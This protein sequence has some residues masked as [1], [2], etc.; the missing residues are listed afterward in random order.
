M[1]LLEFTKPPLFRWLFVSGF[2]I[3]T[4]LFIVNASIEFGFFGLSY[5]ELQKRN[6]SFSQT[7]KEKRKAATL[8]RGFE[9]DPRDEFG[10]I[11]EMREQNP[12]LIKSQCA[13]DYKEYFTARNY[14]PLGGLSNTTTIWGKERGQFIIYQSD[15]YGFRNP[16]SVWDNV[17]LDNQADI[18]LIG[19]SVAQGSSVQTEQSIAGLLRLKN[20]KVINLA[21]NSN[22]PVKSL[23]SLRE[24][25]KGL[26]AK[27]VV[28][29][30]NGIRHLEYLRPESHHPVLARY[31]KDNSFSQGLKNIQGQ[32]D[33]DVREN[34]EL[35]LAKENNHRDNMRL[36]NQKDSAIR[37]LLFGR[38]V[39]R[40]MNEWWSGHIRKNKATT[41][42][43]IEDTV[44][45]MGLMIKIKDI[46]SKMGS[47]FHVI[48]VPDISIIYGTAKRS[49]GTEIASKYDVKKIIFNEMRKW[50]IK[51]IDLEKELSDV[52]PIDDLFSLGGKEELGVYPSSYG[53][54][55]YQIIAGRIL[56]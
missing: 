49:E 4:A 51:I 31:I 10:Y 14:L 56:K 36:I 38:H 27:N 5:I 52:N 30:L 47:T 42:S 44:Q 19:S 28:Y 34:Y 26:R 11:M 17:V 33:R 13:G 41:K 32:I 9:Y 20:I 46:S 40:L 53:P 6:L 25:G 15:R 8:K 23:A 12:T 21:C 29:I 50:G 3:C 2:V 55:A 24:Y 45:F 7:E 35:W 54:R 16:D 43:L 1:K 48:Y 18:V 22:G 37:R 39:R